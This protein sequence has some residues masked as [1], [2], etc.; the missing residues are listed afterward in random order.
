MCPVLSTLELPNLV[1]K[2]H[3]IPRWDSGLETMEEPQAGR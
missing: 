1:D 3:I 2:P